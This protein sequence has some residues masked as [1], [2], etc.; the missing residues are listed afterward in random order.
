MINNRLKSVAEFVDLNDS[1]LDVGC[2]HGYLSIYLKKNNLC[3]NVIASDISK[4]ALNYAIDNFKKYKVSINYYV[5]DGLKSINEFFDTIVISGMG[6]HTIIDILSSDKITD[7]II[8][9]S[10]NDHYLLRKFMYKLGYKLDSEI[11]IN[12]KHKYYPIMCYKKGKDTIKNIDL[13]YGKSNNIDYYNYLLEKNRLIIKSVPFIKK[14]KLRYQNY[15]LCIKIK[16]STE[17]K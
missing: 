1:V 15:L 3:K 17:K 6:T 16:G 4:N 10:N 9:S 7:K 13:I 14:I 12:E 8:L 11:V 5:S 2:D